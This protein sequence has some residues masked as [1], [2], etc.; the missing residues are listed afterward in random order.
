MIDIVRPD[1]KMERQISETKIGNYK[2]VLFPSQHSVRHKCFSK[3]CHRFDVW[4]DPPGPVE[5]DAKTAVTNSGS[6]KPCNSTSTSF[7]CVELIQIFLNCW[8]LTCFQVTNGPMTA[9]HDA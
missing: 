7:D 2:Y 8:L 3:C 6:H 4:A 1:S 5:S 9:H